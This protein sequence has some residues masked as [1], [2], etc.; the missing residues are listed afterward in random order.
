MIPL[1]CLYLIGKVNLIRP[2]VLGRL[3]HNV[4]KANNNVLPLARFCLTC[5]WRRQRDESLQSLLPVIQ[6]NS[7]SVV[8]A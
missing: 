5:F 4:E 8:L 7:G 1:N 2:L 6:L 3:R